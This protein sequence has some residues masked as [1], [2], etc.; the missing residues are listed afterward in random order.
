MT[1]TEPRPAEP[2][3]P[4]GPV[5]ANPPAPGL[6]LPSGSVLRRV[7]AE[8]VHILILQ[9]ALVLEVAHPSV[10][11]GVDHHSRFR[12]QPL[13]RFWATVDAGLRMVW[14][15]PA[16]AAAAARQ[17]HRVHDRVHGAVPGSGRPYT[18]HDADLLR[19]VWATLVD[20][21]EVAHGTFLRPLT[22]TERDRLYADMVAFATFFGIPAD[23]LPPDR[24]TFGDWYARR[25]AD[26]ELGA[27]P[28]SRRLAREILWYRHP[29]VPGPAVA[30]LRLLALGTLPPEVRD[31][32][33]LPFDAAD[34]RRH[35]RARRL[36]STTLRAVP[37]PVRRAGPAAYVAVRS[38]LPGAAG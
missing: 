18:A 34:R 6:D 19:W 12:Q 4:G 27:T 38:L 14:G 31:R 23:L 25:L 33:G 37:G 22:G 11:A 16:V 32:L 7:A 3:A 15:R 26:P 2:D 24:A 1:T 28:H 35:E 5:L 30:P 36:I 10:G 29:V 8:P 13:R 17:V 20:N 9:R 21:I